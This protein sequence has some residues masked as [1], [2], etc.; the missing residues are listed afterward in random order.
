MRIVPVRRLKSTLSSMSNYI[1]SILDDEYKDFRPIIR[2]VENPINQAVRDKTVLSEEQVDF[3]L[4]ELVKDGQ[5]EKACLVALGAYSGRR[6]KELVRFKVD[7]FKDE[8]IIYGSLYKTPEK[9]KTKG[10]GLGKFLHVYVLANK[11]KQYFDLWMDERIRTG[12]ESEWLFP[13]TSD[14]TKHMDADTI[15]S[16]VI[17]FSRILG[18]PFTFTL[19]HHMTTEL[20]KSGL[21]DDIIKSLI[22]WESV[23]MV[24]IYKDVD[25]DEEIGKYFDEDGIKTVEKAKLSDL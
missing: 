7:F 3:L 22:G 13:H 1:E 21:P 9:I 6:K 2:K 12:V 15:N 19:R 5:Y 16:W 23:E 18:V 4:E 8:N 14:S 17:T 11:F 20:S 25:A 10:R 24:S